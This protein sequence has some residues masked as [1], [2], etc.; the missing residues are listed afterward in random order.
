MTPL[1]HYDPKDAI[2]TQNVA[3]EAL[4]EEDQLREME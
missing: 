1:A 3:N 2:S 4:A